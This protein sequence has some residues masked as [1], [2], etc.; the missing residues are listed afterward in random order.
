MRPFGQMDKA[1]DFGSEDQEF[2]SPKG[3]EFFRLTFFQKFKKANNK[4][5]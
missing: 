2:E 5:I 3:C 1:S 4:S